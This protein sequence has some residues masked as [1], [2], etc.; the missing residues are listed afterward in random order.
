MYIQTRAQ[1]PVHRR[2]GQV[3][4]LLLAEGQFGSQAM[5][6]TWVEGAPGSVQALHE[7]PHTEQVYV[8]IRGH[9][10]MQCGVERQEVGAG[11]LVYVP[12]GTP[13]AIRNTGD[14]PLVYVSATSPPL[15]V[16]APG[17]VWVYDSEQRP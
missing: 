2:G 3:S 10:L 4:S 9:G 8:I 5:S 6:I 11:T 17:R 15:P 12:P 1:S 7:H 13:H 16:S 14:E